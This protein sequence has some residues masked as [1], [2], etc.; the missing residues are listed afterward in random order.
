MRTTARGDGRRLAARHRNIELGLLAL[1]V[2]VCLAGHV[3]ASLA[4]TGRMPPGLLVHGLSLGALAG[5]AHLAVRRFAPY[6]DPLILPLG[7]FLTGFGLV[8]LD[9][10]DFSYKAAHTAKGDYQ[11]IPAA[12]SQLMWV[13]ISVAVA[14]ALIVLVKH[15]RFFQ[16][17]VYLLMAGALILLAAPV[18]S[19]GDSFGAKR[20]IRLFGLSFE[21]D[22]F[23]KVA[24][25]IFFAGYLMASR[26]ALAL[27]GRKV[28]G[29]TLP[30]GRHAGPVL[31]IW[32]VSLL[33]L[34]FERDLG[35]SLIFF[36]VF[37][38]MLYVAT[39]RT[40]W[41][42]LGL[43]MAVGGAAVVGTVEPH[44]HGRVEAW[45]HPLDY[46]KPVH[47]KAISE[48][49]AEA[50]FSLGTGHLT[51]T[52]LGSGRP[53]LIGFAG[54]SDF[55]FTTIGEELGLAGVTAI[56]LV[57]VLLIQRGLRTA[58]GLTD[59]F[60]KL[61]ATGLSAALAL[62]VFVVVGGVSGLVPLTGK[63]LP[64]LAAGGSSLLANWLMVALLIKLSDSS[65]RTALDPVQ[66]SPE[67]LPTQAGPVERPGQADPSAAGPLPS[68]PYDPYG[69]YDPSAPDPT[70]PNPSNPALATP[71]AADPSA[72]TQL[73]PAYGHPPNPAAP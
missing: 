32:V 57:Y 60:G 14:L 40:S 73:R 27:A 63:A 25:T 39:E 58:I 30:R 37:I 10:L 31:A 26:D 3:D 56:L 62:Q 35:T 5:A 47:D 12:P 49:P 8:L 38:V 20:W 70:G 72:P 45:L 1:A 15:H 7:A 69:P 65:G 59:P 42:V 29:L 48:Q 17:Y 23:V 33:V 52:G 61:L 44:V 21:P 34:I 54:R 64:F 36:G 16:R 50:L 4:L 53:W 43:L 6:A 13:F 67:P 41:V 55:I 51:G 11:K 2:A 22:E 9:R 18:L 19:P 28:W 68:G 66:P 71:G 46:Y 24:I